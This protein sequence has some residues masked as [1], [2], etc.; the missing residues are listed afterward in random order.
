MNRSMSSTRSQRKKK[1]KTPAKNRKK[2]VKTKRHRQEEK[3]NWVL[4][5]KTRL[6]HITQMEFQTYVYLGNNSLCPFAIERKS[7]EKCILTR[8]E[9]SFPYCFFLKRKG[10]THCIFSREEKLLFF[11]YKNI[12]K[13]FKITKG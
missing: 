7:A 4:R 6:L 13:D 10:K 3:G 12:K 9:K 2:K 8:L 11:I 5:E 1:R